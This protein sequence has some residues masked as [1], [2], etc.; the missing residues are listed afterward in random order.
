MMSIGALRLAIDDWNRDQGKRP[1]VVYLREA[2]A[3]LKSEIGKGVV[4]AE[5]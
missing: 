4:L 2:F 1:I 5:D 3:G